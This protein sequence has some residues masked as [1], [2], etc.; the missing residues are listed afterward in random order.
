MNNNNNGGARLIAHCGARRVSRSELIDIPI[1][2]ATRTHKPVAHFK[3]VQNLEEALA[4]RHLKIIR[5]EYAV[6]NDGMKMF[7]VMDLNAEFLDCKFS[8]GLRNSNDKSMRLAMTAGYRVTVCDN[9]MFSGDF[10]PLS[11][12]HTRNFELI[13]SISI[14]VDRIQRSF[15]PIQKQVQSMKD[16]SLNDAI[17]KLIIYQAFLEK[18]V[19]GIPKHLMGKVHKHYFKPNYKEF[20][21]RNLWSLSNAFTS[22]FK[23]MNPLKH[24]E[25]T[26]RLG[27]FMS[28]VQDELGQ[29]TN[30]DLYLNQNGN[31]GNG[32]S[33]V[34][35][36]GNGI[37]GLPNIED[38]DDDIIFDEEE[39]EFDEYFDPEEEDELLEDVIERL[40]RE[41]EKK[42]TQQKETA[43]QQAA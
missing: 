42:N 20:E 13:D 10:N 34:N 38:F 16:L 12:K 41:E 19:K 32:I 18:K 14:A 39:D 21:D 31:S 11:H 30:L 35:N 36:N 15:L 1:P 3:I 33:K 8:I 4:F 27:T 5:D 24:F 6:S 26:A 37:K 25:T 40:D 22:A 29:M 7:G 43:L 17:A 23:V 2:E 28:D 9:M